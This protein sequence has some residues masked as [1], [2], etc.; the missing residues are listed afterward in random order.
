MPVI[1]PDAKKTSSIAQQQQKQQTSKSAV[2]PIPIDSPAGPWDERNIGPTPAQ[3]TTTQTTTLPPV[4][5]QNMLYAATQSFITEKPQTTQ[6][7]TQQVQPASPDGVDLPTPN[8]LDYA[9]NQWLQEEKQKAF[10]EY[11]QQI[12]EK[13]KEAMEQFQAELRTKLT[14]P[15]Y[16]V[17]TP[18]FSEYMEQQKQYIQKET[19][20]AKSELEAWRKQELAKA[21]QYAVEKAK[22]ESRQIATAHLAATAGALGV[23]AAPAAALTGAAA[24]Q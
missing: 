11:K 20:R 17:N 24:D 1:I 19:E 10:E 5:F 7:T 15:P 14:P 8:R 12:E 23:V 22:A 16:A 3:Q 21:E 2:K 13:E 4:G 18:E 9:Y 6:Q